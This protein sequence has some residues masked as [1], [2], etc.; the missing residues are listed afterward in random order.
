MTIVPLSTIVAEDERLRRRLTDH[1][2]A[3]AAEVLPMVRAYLVSR[4]YQATRIDDEIFTDF[5][6]I[7]WKSHNFEQLDAHVWKAQPWHPGWLDHF[8]VAPD[9][10]PAVAEPRRPNWSL[11]AD[12]FYT[13]ALGY[14]D[15]LS[16]G[17][18]S[19]IRAAVAAQPGD[20]IT[21]ILPT[22]AGKTEVVLSRALKDRPRLTCLIVPTTS[23]ALDLERRVQQLTGN[24]H[25]LAYHSDLTAE[26][27]TDFVERIRSGEQ[28]LVITS[29]EA[30][31]TR[32]AQ[33]LVDAASAGRLACIGIDEAH[34]V[35]EWGDAFRPAFQ[36]LAGLRNRVLEVSPAGKLPVTLMLTAT[37]DDYG[38]DTLRRLFSGARNL[39]VSAQATR[40][41]PAWW[42]YRCSSEDD[43]RT[44]LL[45]LIRFLPR[46]LIVYTSLHSSEKSTNVNTALWWL[47]QAGINAVASVAGDSSPATRKAAVEGL[48]LNGIPDRDLDIV[49]ATSAFGLGIDIRNIRAVIH[50]CMP[51]SVDRLYQEV[52][53][54]G[55]DG[56][57]SASFVLWTDTDREVAEDLAQ[58]RLIG[59]EK[60]WKRW[61]SMS[62]SDETEGV[63]TVDLTASHDEVK[64]PWGDM[65]R[66]WNM[67]TLTAMDRAGMINLDWPAP[68][69]HIPDEATDE[70]LQ[71]YFAARRASVNVRILHGDLGNEG[72]FRK[73][74]RRA[75]QDA[76]D[77][78]SASLTSAAEILDGLAG[79]VNS[80]LARHYALHV[81]GDVYPVDTQCGGCP[82]CRETHRRPKI[83]LKPAQALFHGYVKSEPSST[84]SKLAVD[85]R[86]CIW[87]EGAQPDEEQELVDRLVQKHGVIALLSTGP[88]A[89]RP[90]TTDYLW[91]DQRI[92]EWLNSP[93]YLRVPIV[94]RVDDRTD[95][96]DLRRLLSKAGRESFVVILSDR[97]QPDPFDDRRQLRESWGIGFHINQVLRRL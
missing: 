29:P 85:N 97:D 57:A 36:T 30:A 52:G 48:R 55:R 74:F 62:L 2:R 8:G 15:F 22:G 18:R 56:K 53:R 41:E 61:H 64:Y 32:L 7:E 27:K 47:R 92:T 1:R 68:D 23:L 70:E 13:A 35:A 9:F 90:T 40:P 44:K 31:C 33:P 87:T 91:W 54:G 11:S 5:S 93:H 37:L 63:I 84:L 25:I 82:Y 42:S 50:L 45:E 10:A 79:C 71:D 46:P 60:A 69:H 38:H 75:Q 28:W 14:P 86:L 96:S 3:S 19:A 73:R 24:S 12:S 16:P 21:A 58:A 78:S 77:A 72:A 43:K 20:S 83:S 76:R 51:E 4:G 17:Q 66:Y 39:L 89:P 59:D 88:W 94:I 65:N 80:Y 26:Q 81:D 34:M 49:V 6:E 95:T 67:H